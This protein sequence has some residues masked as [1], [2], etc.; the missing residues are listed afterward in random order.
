MLEWPYKEEEQGPPKAERLEPETITSL[1]REAGFR[2][3][4]QQA[5]GRPVLY[6]LT[7]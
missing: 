1:V 7:P 6:L 3:E 5:L 2:D 4:R